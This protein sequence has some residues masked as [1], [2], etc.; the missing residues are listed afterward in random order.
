MEILVDYGMMIVIGLIVLSY[1]T[2][3]V[4]R[5][6]RMT[7][8]QRLQELYTVIRK[9]VEQADLYMDGEKGQEKLR[10]VYGHFAKQYPGLAQMITFQQF[11][12]FVEKVLADISLEERI[13]E[14]K[15]RK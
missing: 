15:E 12:D 8:E 3:M 7:P 5:A 2:Y 11:A 6:F 13:Q 1:V 9:L 14:K 4:V 10:V